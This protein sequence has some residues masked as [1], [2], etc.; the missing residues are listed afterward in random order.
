MTMLSTFEQLQYGEHGSHVWFGEKSAFTQK[1]ERK[2][3]SDNSNTWWV[4][5]FISFLFL[6]AKND[7]YIVH[8]NRLMQTYLSEINCSCLIVTVQCNSQY[9]LCYIS[10]INYLLCQ[11]GR[12]PLALKCCVMVLQKRNFLKKRK[13][14]KK[15]LINYFSIVKIYCRNAARLFLFMS[16]CM[17]LLLIFI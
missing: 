16:V 10:F 11:R 9:V 1:M 7:K 3:A 13:Y 8:N 12:L 5:D 17:Y 2:Q 4:G 6:R 14:T 15:I